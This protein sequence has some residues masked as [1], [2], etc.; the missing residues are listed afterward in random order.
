MVL[1][2]IEKQVDNSITTIYLNGVN[3]E[4][5]DSLSI[6]NEL[7]SNDNSTINTLD[8]SPSCSCSSESDTDTDTD[9]DSDSDSLSDDGFKMKGLKKIRDCG[10]LYFCD[11]HNIVYNVN[12]ERIGIRVHDESCPKKHKNGKYSERCWWYVEYEK[13]K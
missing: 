13:D 10:R 7:S 6:N 4:K 2:K 5:K 3:K 1:D 11:C 9:S 8:N 12:N